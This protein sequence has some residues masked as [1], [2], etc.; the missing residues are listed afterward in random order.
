MKQVFDDKQILLPSGYPISPGTTAYLH[1]NDSLLTM[2]NWNKIQGA[3]GVFMSF[4]GMGI[5]V[6]RW[7]K[8]AAPKPEMHDKEFQGYMAEVSTTERS[9][10]VMEASGKT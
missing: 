1:R 10:N 9:L 5:V 7:F 8:G 2:E 3:F 6:V 4:S